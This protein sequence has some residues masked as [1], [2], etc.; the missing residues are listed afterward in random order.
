MR[1]LGIPVGRDFAPQWDSYRSS[2]SW[3]TLL[4]DD[5]KHYP[6]LGFEANIGTWQIFKNFRCPKI[7]RYTYSIN[8]NSL[9][10][11]RLGEPLPEFLNQPNIEDVTSEYIPVSNV[12]R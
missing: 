1:S 10:A 2:H 7:F 5:G 8:R 6:F 3:N 12:Y 4:S 9:A 11:Q